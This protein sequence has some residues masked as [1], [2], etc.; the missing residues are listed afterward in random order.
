MDAD[1]PER[2]NGCKAACVK[3]GSPVQQQP[4]M[5]D[6]ARADGIGH[7]LNSSWSSGV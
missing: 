6:N 1:G 3:G 5:P 7:D 4:R 2:S